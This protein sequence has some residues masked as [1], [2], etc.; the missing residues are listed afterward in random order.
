MYTDP[1]GLLG[2]PQ[3]VGPT[4]D[5]EGVGGWRLGDDASDEETWKK[6]NAKLELPS[7]HAKRHRRSAT[8]GSIGARRRSLSPEAIGMNS[9]KMR[10]AKTPSEGGLGAGYNGNGM[11]DGYFPLVERRRGSCSNQSSGSSGILMKAREC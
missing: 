1:P 2:L 7:D 5:Y 11:G 10:A 9:G 6:F 4:R 8:G 3:S